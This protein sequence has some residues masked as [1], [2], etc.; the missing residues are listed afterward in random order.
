MAR[1]LWHIWE[2]REMR[3]GFFGVIPKERDHL[4]DLGIDGNILLKRIVGVAWEA[5]TGFVWLKMD[6]SGGLL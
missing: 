1:G 4:Q 2:L 6:T 3:L 5:W